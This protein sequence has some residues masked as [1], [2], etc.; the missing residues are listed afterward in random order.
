MNQQIRNN[1]NA[2]P[3]DAIR[4]L[5]LNLSYSEV[6]NLCC[7][8]ERFNNEICKNNIF[9]AAQCKAQLKRKPAELVYT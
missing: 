2:L 3:A 7:S 8:L 5:A 9:R 6:I 4:L 1:I